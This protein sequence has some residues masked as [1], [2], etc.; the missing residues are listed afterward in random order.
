MHNECP[1]ALDFVANDQLG[2][3]DGEFRDIAE[4]RGGRHGLCRCRRRSVQIERL[5]VIRQR[6][7][8]LD[9]TRIETVPDLSE[10]VLAAEL[11]RFQPPE[12]RPEIWLFLNVRRDRS[13][14]EV[15][16]DADGCGR[17]KVD[18]T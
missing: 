18:D 14:A 9:A 15:G 4:G 2:K 7:C 12:E 5:P 11:E 6:R 16:V 17:S 13:H 1:D 8:C 3:D 10:H